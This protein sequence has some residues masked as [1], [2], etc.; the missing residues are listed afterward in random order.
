[1]RI[2]IEAGDDYT[3]VVVSHNSSCFRFQFRDNKP[4]RAFAHV[5]DGDLAVDAH[6]RGFYV[7][8]KWVY[9]EGDI[10][11]SFPLTQELAKAFA[12]VGYNVLSPTDTSRVS[13][14]C[15]THA[16]DGQRSDIPMA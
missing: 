11:N 14:E 15:S 2:Y 13:A 7:N 10:D 6:Y 12:K 16:G 8:G 9:L 3:E 1:M 4:K 5:E